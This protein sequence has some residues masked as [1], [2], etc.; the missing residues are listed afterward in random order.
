MNLYVR[1]IVILLA[2]VCQNSLRSVNGMLFIPVGA[3]VVNF[4]V[5]F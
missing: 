2:P 3:T 5:F 4:G 1:V